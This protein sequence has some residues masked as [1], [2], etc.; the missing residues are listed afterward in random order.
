MRMAACPHAATIANPF[1][2]ALRLAL[3]TTSD[4]RSSGYLTPCSW[5][6]TPWALACY[7]RD[8]PFRTP[9]AYGDSGYLVSGRKLLISEAARDVEGGSEAVSG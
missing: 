1:N 5:L 9:C 7:W 2:Q 3:S 8:S 6:G 4:S